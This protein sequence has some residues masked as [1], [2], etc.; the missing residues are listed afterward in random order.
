MCCMHVFEIESN[1]LINL[2]SYKTEPISAIIG[3]SPMSNV[4]LDAAGL[5][6]ERKPTLKRKIEYLKNLALLC[7]AFVPNSC[8]RTK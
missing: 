4:Q 6:D 7:T 2:F 5:F 8:R 3:Q 1:S